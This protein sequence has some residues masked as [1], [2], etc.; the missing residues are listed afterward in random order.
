MDSRSPVSATIVVNFLSCSS[1]EGCFMLS[2]GYNV[3][4]KLKTRILQG[5]CFKASYFLFKSTNL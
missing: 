1:W 2:G 3:S 5:S 4:I